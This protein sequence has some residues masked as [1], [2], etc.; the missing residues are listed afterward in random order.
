AVVRGSDSDATNDAFQWA[1]GSFLSSDVGGGA[2]GGDIT[3]SLE[4]TFNATASQG[5]TQADLDNDGD[6]DVGSNDNSNPDNFFVA[7]ADG[8]QGGS[9]PAPAEWRI[10]TWS[11]TVISQKGGGRTNINFRPRDT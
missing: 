4:P 8:M 6:L 3:A 1:H 11:F 9:A 10:G 2:A 7:R 5:G